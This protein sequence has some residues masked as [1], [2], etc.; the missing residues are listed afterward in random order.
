MCDGEPDCSDAEDEFD[1]GKII[2]KLF[3]SFFGEKAFSVA[4]Y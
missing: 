4:H 1:C 2:N 3:I